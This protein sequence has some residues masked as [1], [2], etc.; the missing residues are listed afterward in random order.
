MSASCGPI[1]HGFQHVYFT[2]AFNGATRD[3]L[4]AERIRERLPPCL[5]KN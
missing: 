1:A 4:Y 3:I 5:D 2:P